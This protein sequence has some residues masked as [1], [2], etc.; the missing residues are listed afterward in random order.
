MPIQTQNVIQQL[1]NLLCHFP[2]IPSS[3]LN[4]EV[5]PAD[6][7]SVDIEDNTTTKK[8]T[9][10]LKNFGIETYVNNLC[11]RNANLNFGSDDFQV[12]NR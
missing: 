10:D 12:K 5:V 3:S 6:P 4:K 9:V 2:F 1:G 7:A 11:L 8:V